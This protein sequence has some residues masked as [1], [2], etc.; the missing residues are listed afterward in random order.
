MPSKERLYIALYARGGSATMP[1]GEDKYHWAILIGPK[2]EGAGA[3]GKRFHATE[4]M[5]VVNG[6]AQPVWQFE[7]RDIRMEP[8][9]MILVRVIVGKVRKRD[10]VE[11][12]L[13]SIPV[14]GQTPGWNCV[15]WVQEALET[16]QQHQESGQRILENYR[17]NWDTVRYWELWYVQYKEA[18]HR[19]D[20]QAAPG[21]F[22]MG[23]VPTYDLL[24]ESEQ[25]P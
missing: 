11:A 21:T 18:E 3:Q 17:L 2:K 7:E 10:Q 15:H 13:R 20:G 25:T 24:K 1:G 4:S 5:T 8:T 19:F 16:L 23:K 22:D 9:N 6:Q 14:R 12:I